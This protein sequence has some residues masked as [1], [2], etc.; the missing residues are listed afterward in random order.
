MTRRAEKLLCG[1]GAA[2]P[3]PPPAPELV[4][5][6]Y[7]GFFS[8]FFPFKTVFNETFQEFDESWQM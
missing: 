8:L 7:S 3:W 5:V 2:A 6:C 1:R 4:F